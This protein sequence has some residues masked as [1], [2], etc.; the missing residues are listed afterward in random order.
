MLATISPWIDTKICIQAIFCGDAWMHLGIEALIASSS[1]SMMRYLR[2]YAWMAVKHTA[3]TLASS[4]FAHHGI[5]HFAIT[6]G[7]ALT[8]SVEGL[9]TAHICPHFLQPQFDYR[10]GY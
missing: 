9:Q 7:A 10:I 2:K 4:N 1:D 6:V 8:L 3:N 5:D